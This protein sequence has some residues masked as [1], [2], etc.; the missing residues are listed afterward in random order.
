MIAA[1]TEAARHDVQQKDSAM[2]ATTARRRQRLNG[3]CIIQLTI[4]FF[5]NK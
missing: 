1:C 5:N 4:Y 3:L 2:L